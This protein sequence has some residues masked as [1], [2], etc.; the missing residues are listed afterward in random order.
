MMFPPPIEGQDAVE[1]ARVL[2]AVLAE[3]SR[4]DARGKSDGIY[5]LFSLIVL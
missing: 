4:G 3:S 1:Y 2:A 5:S